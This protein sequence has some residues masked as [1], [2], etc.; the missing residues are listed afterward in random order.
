[1]LPESL[2]LAAARAVI[3]ARA[4][5]DRRRFLLLVLTLLAAGAILRV[6]LASRQVVDQFGRTG[7]VVV[8]IDDLAPGHVIAPGDLTIEH[9]PAGLVPSGAATNEADV[10]GLGV[11][12]TITAGEAVVDFRLGLGRLGLLADERALTLP[13]PLAPPP[14][15][16]GDEVD[17]FAVGVVDIG[18]G[19]VSSV[20]MRL[21]AGRVLS[22]SETG[23]TVAVAEAAVG[24][25]LEA[26][27]VGTIEI[28]GRP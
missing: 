12:S 22:T 19:R 25:L 8:A 21:T 24:A 1:M 26:L 13:P 3:F 16:V 5:W 17:L 23:I 18:D 2:S 11:R 9:W 6:V 27:A 20:T 4:H 28:V 10:V 7:A 15:I 14:L